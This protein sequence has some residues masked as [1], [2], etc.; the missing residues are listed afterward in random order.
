MAPPSAADMLLLLNVFL[1]RILS[2]AAGEA[3]GATSSG[4]GGVRGGLQDGRD[5]TT[6]AGAAHSA[7]GL[8]LWRVVC[9]RVRES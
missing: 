2:A 5:A 6:G 7:R 1:D 9:A 8:Q 3:A 4:E